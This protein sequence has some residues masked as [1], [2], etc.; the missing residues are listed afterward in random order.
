MEAVKIGPEELDV[1]QFHDFLI[2][3]ERF[4]KRAQ[5]ELRRTAH[6]EA[7]HAVLYAKKKVPFKWVAVRPLL[8]DQQ[9]GFEDEQMDA[10]DFGRVHCGTT[11]RYGGGFNDIS[12]CWHQELILAY[13]G[14]VA[15]A[16]FLGS[17]RVSVVGGD[18]KMVKVCLDA[19][20]QE[21]RQLAEDYLDLAKLLVDRHWHEIEAVA[22]AL[23]ER[24]ILTT[25]EVN[26]IIRASGIEVPYSP[27]R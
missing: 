8:P 7:G 23:I 20:Y 9:G 27:T 16:R 24:R 14:P 5:R 21:D 19:A 26:K 3:Q 25:K 22:L 4:R 13:A 1:D 11:F 10:F 15:E 12:E 17:T 18:L 2:R 6:H